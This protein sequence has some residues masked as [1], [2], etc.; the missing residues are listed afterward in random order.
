[1]LRSSVREGD[2]VYRYGGEE[3]LVVFTD[4]P[5]GEAWGAA[6]RLRL[7]V[8][9][10]PLSGENLEPVGPV[11]ISIGLALIPD[12]GTD[13]ETLIGRADK[14]MYRAKQGGRN[15]VEVWDESDVE[16]LD[17]VA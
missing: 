13:I 7:A 16:G 6:E 4:T 10:A 14:A 15:R 9:S 5:R 8:E 2:R 12:H 3:F 17:S 11:T 1:V